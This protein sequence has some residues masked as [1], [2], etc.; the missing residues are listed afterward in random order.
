M[1]K[2]TIDYSKQGINVDEKYDGMIYNYLID[3]SNEVELLKLYDKQMGIKTKPKQQTMAFEYDMLS[4]DDTYEENERTM[5]ER[6]KEVKANKEKK[7]LLLSDLKDESLVNLHDLI[8]NSDGEL[9]GYTMEKVKGESIDPLYLSRKDKINYLSQIRDIMLRLNE[10]NIFIGDFNSKNFIINENNKVI[11]TNIDNFKV[12]GNDFDI[13]TK[14]MRFYLEDN[15]KEELIDRYCFNM[16]AISALAK[17]VLGYF[18]VRDV[19]LPLK[20]WINKHNREAMEE[21][22]IVNENY[23]GKILEFEKKKKNN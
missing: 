1:E 6:V 22:Y 21:M 3:N 15:G 5:E 8:C 2:K 4:F 17:Y 9:V 16:L 19:N 7:L 18:D 13:K 12:Y 11:C 14:Y 20:L 10:K 23:T